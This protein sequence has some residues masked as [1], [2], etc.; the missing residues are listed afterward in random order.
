M[1]YTTYP[2]VQDFSHQQYVAREHS[3]HLSNLVDDF[4]DFQVALA[5]KPPVLRSF[6]LP[7]QG[8][9]VSDSRWCFLRD[10]GLLKESVP[11]KCSKYNMKQMKNTEKLHSKRKCWSVYHHICVFRS[12]MMNSTPPKFNPDTKHSGLE[13]LHTVIISFKYGHFWY[14]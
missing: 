11:W 10:N 8:G 6:F 12:R 9:N 13:K 3:A 2:L 5:T 1:V 4:V 14:L 7:S